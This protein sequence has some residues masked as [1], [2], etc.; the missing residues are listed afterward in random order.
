M[1]HNTCINNPITL[2]FYSPEEQ[3]PETDDWKIVIVKTYDK[4]KIDFIIASYYEEDNKW[5]DDHLYGIEK[6][7]VIAWATFSLEWVVTERG[8]E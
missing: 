6:D 5:Y 1:K 2:H 8:E 3:L 7:D 4:R